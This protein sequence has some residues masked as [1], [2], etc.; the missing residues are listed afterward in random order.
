MEFKKLALQAAGKYAQIP[1]IEAVMLAGSVSRN[2]QDEF[3]DIELLLFWKQAPSEEERIQIIDQ[4][5]GKLLEF[6][7]YEEEEWAETYT[8]DGVKFEI[9]SFLTET[10]RQTIHQV[11]RK[12]DVNP[13]LQCIAA[14][15][16]HGIALYGDKTVKQLKKEIEHYPPGLQ[17]EVINHYSDFGSRWNNRKALVHRKDWLMFYKVIVSVQTNIMGLLFGLNRQFISHPAFKWQRNSLALMEIKPG[18]C[19]ARLESVFFQE[20]SEA[21]KELETLIEEIFG[22]IHHELPHIDLSD[23]ARKAA[24]VRPKT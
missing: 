13:D 20:P 4:L 2:W 9:S 10:I 16:Q 23:A 5:D 1:N 12:F 17:E 6:H 11:I 19:A 8:V 21:I 14:A 18:N 22:L 15:V 7:P 24:F 3:S